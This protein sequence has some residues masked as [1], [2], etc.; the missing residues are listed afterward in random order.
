VIHEF[1]NL[2]PL[3]TEQAN[4]V[5]AVL[6]AGPSL[7]DMAEATHY[8]LARFLDLYTSPEVRAHIAAAKDAATDHATIRLTEAAHTAVDTLERI[9]EN[10]ENDQTERRRAA[11]TILRSLLPRPDGGGVRR[12]RESDGGGA[13]AHDMFEDLI[14]TLVQLDAGAVR[15]VRESDSASS[16]VPTGEVS[17]ESSSLTEGVRARTT[18]SN[19]CCAR[20]RSLTDEVSNEYSSLTQGAIAHDPFESPLHTLAHAGALNPAN[21]SEPARSQSEPTSVHAQSTSPSPLTHANPADPR[22]AAGQSLNRL[23]TTGPQAIP[24]SRAL[25]TA[26][27]RPP[28][29]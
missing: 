29:Q 21:T 24:K 11:T 16:P 28:P 8:D 27:P 17:N 5:A 23:D 1:T 25:R 3:T 19:T 18:H 15:R 22:A 9:A 4:V 2:P 7:T 13:S 12:V 14:R 20:S 10:P 26:P 6:T